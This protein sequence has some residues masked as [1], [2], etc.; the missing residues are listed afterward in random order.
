MSRPDRARWT[1]WSAAVGPLLVLVANAYAV[2]HR[3]PWADRGSWLFP[4]GVAAVFGCGV[5]GYAVAAAFDAWR[6]RGGRRGTNG[7]PPGGP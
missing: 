1:F 6:D 7:A 5:I 4:A 2:H 3:F